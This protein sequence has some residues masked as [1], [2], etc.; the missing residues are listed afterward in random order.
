MHY[1]Y[2]MLGWSFNL[3]KI[4][5]IQL[6]VH[7]T[8]LLLLGYWAYQGYQDGGSGGA[9]WSTTLILAIFTCVVLHELGHSLT[10]RHFGVGV[11]RILL[12]PIGGMAEFDAIPRQPGREL[13]IT[14]AGPAVNFVLAGALWIVSDRSSGVPDSA[15][16]SSLGELVWCLLYWN[17]A[18]GI[19]N[20]L[21]AYPMDGGRILRALLATRLPYLRATFWA[22][23]VGKVIAA[24]AA[25]TAF[26]FHR[27]LT[28]TLFTFIFFA[29]EAEYQAL[30]RRERQDAQWRAMLEQLRV[31]PPV[32]EP[33]FL[34]K[35]ET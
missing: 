34:Q 25:L 30:K 9:F 7:V 13:L 31:A 17:I 1:P 29:G 24:G 23:M 4:R 10:A 21:P 27:Y 5:G 15:L 14:A 2:S 11:R 26:Y 18:M 8:F 32:E 28:A 35:P 6:S 20:L 12:M 22:V 33:P 19:F 3:F 16:P